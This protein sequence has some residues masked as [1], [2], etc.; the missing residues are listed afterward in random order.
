MLTCILGANSWLL[1]NERKDQ[2]V[3]NHQGKPTGRGFQTTL[4][5]LFSKGGFF[6]PL[7][8][9]FEQIEDCQ[10]G[11]GEEDQDWLVWWPL[12]QREVFYIKQ[13]GKWPSRVNRLWA[14]SHSWHTRN[15]SINSPYMVTLLNSR[16]EIKQTPSSSVSNLSASSRPPISPVHSFT[17][18]SLHRVIPIWHS[19]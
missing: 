6:D 1:E 14:V 5:T 16:G 13:E 12:R 11:A 17:S 8:K 7:K 19:I 3:A 9:T 4:A 10:Q 18:K 15:Y 2:N